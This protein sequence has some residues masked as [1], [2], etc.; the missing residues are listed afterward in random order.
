[1]KKQVIDTQGAPLP[2]V[3]PKRLRLGPHEE[4]PEVV[5]LPG[6]AATFDGAARTNNVTPA[7]AAPAWRVHPA[8]ALFPPMPADEL[9][10]LADDI[11]KNGQRIPI[12]VTPDGVVLDGRNRLAACELAGVTPATLPS[13]PLSPRNFEEYVIR[14]ALHWARLAE[15]V[16]S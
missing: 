5:S 12:A 15:K 7:T 14:A 16:S 10:A 9:Q 8:A 4:S 11:K 1:M 6:S 13:A 2:D 3:R